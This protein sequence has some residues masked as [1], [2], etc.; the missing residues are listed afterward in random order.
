MEHTSTEGRDNQHPEKDKTFM[1]DNRIAFRFFR[2]ILKYK[3]SGFFRWIHR[4]IKIALALVILWG[5]LIVAMTSWLI[6]SRIP[7]Q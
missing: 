2:L 4:H 6:I 3:D 5:L 1:D 7:K